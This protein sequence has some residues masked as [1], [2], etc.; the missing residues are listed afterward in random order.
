[1]DSHTLKE[2]EDADPLKRARTPERQEKLILE[3]AQALFTHP[4][5][6]EQGKHNPSELTDR[7]LSPW[8]SEQSL[9]LSR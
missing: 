1:M 2:E 4:I 7:M 8:G 6:T 3:L 9:L 5:F